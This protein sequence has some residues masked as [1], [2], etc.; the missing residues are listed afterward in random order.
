[1]YL[2]RQASRLSK[3]HYNVK[4]ACA[5]VIFKNK[6]LTWSA[7]DWKRTPYMA[8]RRVKSSPGLPI[9]PAGGLGLG[10]SSFFLPSAA[11]SFPSTSS[12]SSS[13][14]GSSSGGG[15]WKHCSRF[16]LTAVLCSVVT[17]C[18]VKAF[19]TLFTTFHSPSFYLQTVCRLAP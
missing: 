13:C 4:K 11:S 3:Y 18:G 6:T 19:Q 7:Y 16:V 8:A 2:I 15:S 1:M 9:M 5:F 14:G 10:S 12:F 17:S